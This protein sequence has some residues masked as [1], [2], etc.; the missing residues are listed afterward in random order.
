MARSTADPSVPR[1]GT[2]ADYPKFEQE[3]ALACRACG[4]KGK[5]EVGRIFVDPELIG[6]PNDPAEP[7]EEAFYFSAVFH[8]KHCGGDGPWEFP[9][10]TKTQ[11]LA[12]LVVG[13]HDRTQRQIQLGRIQLFDGTIARTGAQA[14]AYLK[15]MIQINPEDAFLWGR[16]GNFYDND[17]DIERA[18]KAYEKAVELDPGEIESNYTLGCY[19]MKD[20]DEDGAAECFNRV[21]RYA[22][23]APRRNAE[24]L[25]GI[26]RDSLER[27]FDLHQ[28]SEGTIHFPPKF[29]L[30]PPSSES[31]PNVISL[32][33]MD[34]STP[35]AWEILTSICLTGKVP[36]PIRQ[37][38]SRRLGLA[39]DPAR[40]TTWTLSARDRTAVIPAD[41]VGSRA[42][43]KPRVGRNEPC[44]CGSGKKYKRCCGGPV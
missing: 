27:L 41:R 38:E 15:Q 29:D 35:E 21:A 3:V 42:E 9:P 7:I 10:E 25:E 13:V 40:K 32:I 24:L 37:R 5:Y 34:L 11:L 36:E 31:G 23:T 16:L 22:R 44:P 20:G 6:K 39:A 33:E 14:E 30:P 8:C 17:G 18:R 19:R 4:K 43:S 26:V 28:A 12:F 1:K 2:I